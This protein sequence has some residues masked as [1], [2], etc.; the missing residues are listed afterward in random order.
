MG[1]FSLTFL[2]GYVVI[3]TFLLVLLFPVLGP[4]S[5][6]NLQGLLRTA[7]VQ[8]SGMSRKQGSGRAFH[9]SNCAPAARHFLLV[10][11]LLC[12]LSPLRPS[13][14]RD[15][16]LGCC[17]T[18]ISLVSTIRTEDPPKLRLHVPQNKLGRSFPANHQLVFAILHETCR[19]LPLFY[20]YHS[21]FFVRA[22]PG[23]FSRDNLPF[24]T[25]PPFTT[26]PSS[27][28]TSEPSQWLPTAKA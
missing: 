24:T 22:H 4:S 12:T 7:A 23:H 13:R 11:M 16:N 3:K 2:C 10:E 20:L 6:S 28:Q 14:T 9:P 8:V 5:T 21:R 18:R 1:Q 15:N 25:Q 26:N 17:S 27:D 19:P